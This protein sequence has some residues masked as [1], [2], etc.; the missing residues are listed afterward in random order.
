M[1]TRQSA[2]GISSG[3]E[4]ANLVIGPWLAFWNQAPT[5]VMSYGKIA[6]R[7]AMELVSVAFAHA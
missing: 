2:F 4:G 1:D 5:R 7:T 3:L 6:I